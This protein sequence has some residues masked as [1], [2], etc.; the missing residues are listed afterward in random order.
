[1]SKPDSIE[2]LF[3]SRARDHRIQPST[4]SWNRVERRLSRP[5]PRLIWVRSLAATLLLTLIGL[6]A[7]YL[8]S[9]GTDALAQK[10]DSIEIVDPDFQ[11]NAIHNLRASYTALEEG[12]AGK[13]LRVKNERRPILRIS[14]EYR[15]D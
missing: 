2:R 12:E 4:D 7:F 15:V 10:P 5:K 6:S 8:Q 9:K 14:P 1:M 13:T 3:R 11:P